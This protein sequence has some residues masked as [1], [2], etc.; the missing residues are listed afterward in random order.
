MQRPR[1]NVGRSSVPMSGR[2]ATR[3]SSTPQPQ[4]SPYKPREAGAADVPP[5]RVARPTPGTR[6]T[7]ATPNVPRSG[8]REVA[9]VDSAGLVEAGKQTGTPAEPV[10]QQAPV[11][12]NANSG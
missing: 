1:A 10:Q 3:L 2:N 5:Q 11:L 12:N 6:P 9:R 8:S 7:A 4:P